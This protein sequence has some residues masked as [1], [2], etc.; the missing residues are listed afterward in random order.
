MKEK[1]KKLTRNTI[2]STLYL[3]RINDPK[4]I[5][6]IYVLENYSGQCD[7]INWLSKRHKM[8]FPPTG[9]K[10]SYKQINPTKST[11]MESNRSV[12]RGNHIVYDVN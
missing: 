11:S 4:S 8:I 12:K 10:E 5:I 7:S 1:K 6:V 2:L 3:E 9:E